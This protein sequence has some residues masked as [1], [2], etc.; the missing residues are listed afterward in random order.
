MHLDTITK[1]L[2]IT[3]YR[4]AEVTGIEYGSIYVILE[5]EEDTPLFL[6]QNP[7]ALWTAQP[8]AFNLNTKEGSFLT[9]STTRVEV[10]PNFS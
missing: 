1:L 10:T 8:K 9:V 7:S 6:A 4:A 5:R 2:D 3:N